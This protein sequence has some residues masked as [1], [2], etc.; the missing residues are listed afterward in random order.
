MGHSMQR[1]IGRAMVDEEFR[2]ALLADPASAVEAANFDLAPDEMRVLR[3][4]LALASK[5]P[6]TLTRI[7]EL[8]GNTTA[9]IW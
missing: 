6:G 1:V 7:D 4:E 3:E 9:S 5:D 8:L 2:R